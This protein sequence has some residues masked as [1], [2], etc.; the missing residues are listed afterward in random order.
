MV[1][2]IER[3]F[4]VASSEVVVTDAFEFYFLCTR[5]R[6]LAYTIALVICAHDARAAFT[7]EFKL[8]QFL[9]FLFVQGLKF[10][11]GYLPAK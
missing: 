5:I 3:N 6:V 9:A 4:S 7:L 1:F 2:E 8:P 10:F 11:F